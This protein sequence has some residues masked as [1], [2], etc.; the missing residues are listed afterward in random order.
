MIWVQPY[1]PVA[2]AQP[3]YPTAMDGGSAENAGRSF[4]P[5]PVKNH[6]RGT[7]KMVGT[8]QQKRLTST[9]VQDTIC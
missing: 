2:W 9:A 8:K 6:F 1:V 5:W 4:R 3:G 7:T